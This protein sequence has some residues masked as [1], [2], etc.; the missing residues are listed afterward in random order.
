MDQKKKWQQHGV[1]T[2]SC[3]PVQLRLQLAVRSVRHDVLLPAALRGDAADIQHEVG[4]FHSG[5]VRR[6]QGPARLP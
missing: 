5:A 3:P 6:P 2:W 1:S 4:P